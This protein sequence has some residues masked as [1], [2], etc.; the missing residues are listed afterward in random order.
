MST[1]FESTPNASAE[2]ANIVRPGKKG[3]ISYNPQIPA[4]LRG[5]PTGRWREGGEA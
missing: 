4:E 2:K 1:F 3:I 5:T